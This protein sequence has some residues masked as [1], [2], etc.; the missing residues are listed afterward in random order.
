MVAH[1]GVNR[2]ILCSLLNKNLQDL[3]T[4]PQAYGCLNII[5]NEGKERL[6]Q[7]I[8]RNPCHWEWHPSKP[9]SHRPTG[10]CPGSQE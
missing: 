8:N 7:E 1:A 10:H 2:M 5:D 6:V 4:I 9:Q 3:F